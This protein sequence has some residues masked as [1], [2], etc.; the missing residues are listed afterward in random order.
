M[1]DKESEKVFH[2]I[3][4]PSLKQLYLRINEKFSLSFGLKQ[5]I[6]SNQRN[7]FAFTTF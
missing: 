1:L 5:K 3:C 4:A 2:S 7:V 6:K